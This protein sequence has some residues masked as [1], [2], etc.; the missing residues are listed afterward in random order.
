MAGLR[1]VTSKSDQQKDAE[2]RDRL[3]SL[4]MKLGEKSAMSLEQALDKLSTAIVRFFPSASQSVLF[5]IP[6]LFR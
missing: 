2:V 6:S 4:L 5:L 3:K 1:P